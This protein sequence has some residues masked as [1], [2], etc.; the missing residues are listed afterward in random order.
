M[1][2]VVVR[3]IRSIGFMNAGIEDPE[4]RK[5]CPGHIGDVGPEV[6]AQSSSDGRQ[7]LTELDSQEAERRAGQRTPRHVRG[8]GVTFC[9][10]F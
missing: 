9:M 6:F 2:E 10:L 1:G 5:K 3:G 4:V 8:L 7:R